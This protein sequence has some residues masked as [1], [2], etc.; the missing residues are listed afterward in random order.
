M[1]RASFN[2]KKR[3]QK[4][5]G[6]KLKKLWHQERTKKKIRDAE[7][8]GYLRKART[9]LD[10]EQRP[11]NFDEK[12]LAN[13][14]HMTRRRMDLCHQ[15][16]SDDE[17][18]SFHS[19]YELDLLKNTH[20]EY[21]Q[22]PEGTEHV[23]SLESVEGSK[24]GDCKTDPADDACQSVMSNEEEASNKDDRT[25]S[26]ASFK[27]VS[28]HQDARTKLR[29]LSCFHNLGT[30]SLLSDD[31]EHES[32][33]L[34]HPEQNNSASENVNSERSKIARK[35]FLNTQ[36]TWRR[37]SSALRRIAV[38]PCSTMRC[39]LE[40]KW[41]PMMA[42][43]WLSTAIFLLSLILFITYKFCWRR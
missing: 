18:L 21:I 7:D 22:S 32:S 15:Q 43:R 25:S 39:M 33:N 37:L 6:R 31:T 28:G 26:A 11:E 17:N 40:T 36:I 10:W 14:C 1:G 12:N 41:T 3:Q 30:N 24:E 34:S 8:D 42:H 35:L 27:A 2:L 38:S 4:K 16:F 5:G 13:L 20:D 19:T 29:G 9:V 23:D